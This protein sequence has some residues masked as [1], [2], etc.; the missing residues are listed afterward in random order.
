MISGTATLRI[1]HETL[2]R[3]VQEYLERQFVVGSCPQVL[4]IDIACAGV[5]DRRQ[6]EVSLAPPDGLAPV[7]P[8]VEPTRGRRSLDLEHAGPA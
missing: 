3:A 6:F 4:T 8:V 7:A 2:R 5:P 1:S